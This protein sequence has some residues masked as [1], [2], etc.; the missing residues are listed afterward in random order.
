MAR[1]QTYEIHDWKRKFNQRI[2]GWGYSYG[3]AKRLEKIPDKE[4]CQLRH[5][6][7][8][9]EP[10]TFKVRCRNHLHDISLMPNGA[11]VLHQ[12]RNNEILETFGNLTEQRNHCQ[13]VLTAFKHGCALH[14]RLEP[15]VWARSRVVHDRR[16][17]T[18]GESPYP[19]DNE[20]NA[21]ELKDRIGSTKDRA[22]TTIEKNISKSA[23]ACQYGRRHLMP[24][25]CEKFPEVAH[26]PP[27]AYRLKFNIELGIERDEPYTPRYSFVTRVFKSSTGTIELDELS[28]NYSSTYVGIS[29]SRWL[30]SRLYHK[31]ETVFDKTGREYFIL[32][33]TTEDITNPI[34]YL[35]VLAI[36]YGEEID[37]PNRLVDNTEYFP[38]YYQYRGE[39]KRGY[40][41]ASYH[42]ALAD[43]VVTAD[44]TTRQ[45]VSIEKKYAG[46]DPFRYTDNITPVLIMEV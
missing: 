14:N 35:H 4:L 18:N 38:H 19:S 28:D 5:P 16:C 30:R 36:S 23:N 34:N 40:R 33:N 43:T 41:L 26:T 13:D 20:L 32:D 42:Y 45:I 15:W 17:R 1:R 2:H 29:R 24:V 9:K 6:S 11:L 10:V 31:F 25:V 39:Y 27:E 37:P 3:R 21:L 22:I 44:M 8:P 46:L 12:H 7:L